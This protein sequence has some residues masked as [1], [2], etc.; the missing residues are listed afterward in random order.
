M[1][2][3]GGEALWFKGRW[4]WTGG[5]TMTWNLNRNFESDRWNLRPTLRSRV[6]F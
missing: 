1:Y 2:T 4:E 3:L 5:L 6:S